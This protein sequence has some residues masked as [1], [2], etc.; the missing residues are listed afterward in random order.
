MVIGLGF[1]VAYGQSSAPT[2]RP[3]TKTM[4]FRFENASVD[5][6]LDELS[7][8]LGFV[9]QKTEAIPAR[10]TVMAPQKVDADEAV[11]LLNTV[12]ISV[13]YAAIEQPERQNAD[14]TTTRV[15]RVMTFKEAKK[16]G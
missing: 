3:P 4:E 10:V 13:G 5:S 15:L 1:V 2:V 8:R 11:S 6:I 9:I 16:A 14:G 7:T 12:L